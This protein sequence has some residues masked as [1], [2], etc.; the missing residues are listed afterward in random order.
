MD[1]SDAALAGFAES[2]GLPTVPPLDFLNSIGDRA[3][4]SKKK[5]VNRKL[6]RLKEK[7]K[8]EKARKKAGLATGDDLAVAKEA[9]AA[10][11]HA[12]AGPAGVNEA[13]DFDGDD[14]YTR[15]MDRPQSDSDSGSDSGSDSS[16][17]G[18]DSDS[19]SGGDGGMALGSGSDS[20]DLH[21]PLAP[22]SDSDSD[23]D[24]GSDQGGMFTVKQT[25]AWGADGADGDSS[26]GEIERVLTK[27]QKRKLKR[28]KIDTQGVDKHARGT[29][30]V[31][32]ADG[33]A[34][35]DPS[36]KFGASPFDGS[37]QPEDVDTGGTAHAEHVARVRARLAAGKVADD[38][39]HR[40]RL[41]SKRQKHREIVK[42]PL[43]ESGSESDGDEGVQ[44]GGY[45]D[46]SMSDGEGSGSGSESGGDGSA[47]A[48]GS[49]SDAPAGEPVDFQKQAMELLGMA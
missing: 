28:V 40:E 45:S 36:T 41:K 44:L 21:R 23:S 16:G 35:D 43:P 38:E 8:I 20:D 10:K 3:Q 1:H 17:S 46:A 15:P 2:L 39:S 9:K 14:N 24:A 42:G 47:S 27:S 7:I 32:D 25:H 5:N 12:K 11:R 18:S 48:S 13:D 22:A 33:T 31:F 37:V 19:D 29:K 34:V 6:E 30:T 26:D 49:E 4:A